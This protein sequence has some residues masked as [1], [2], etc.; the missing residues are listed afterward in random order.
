MNYLRQY[1]YDAFKRNRRSSKPDC[2]Y[3]LLATLGYRI[4]TIPSSSLNPSG[5]RDFSFSKGNYS[6][7]EW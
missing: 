7:R 1:I 2:S 4:E 6:G 3:E 5:E